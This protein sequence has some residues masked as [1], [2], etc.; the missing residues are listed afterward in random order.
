MQSDDGILYESLEKSLGKEIPLLLRNENINEILLNPDGVIWSDSQIDGLQQVTQIS[1]LQALSIFNKLAGINN[2]IISEKEPI[3][4]VELPYY[5]SMNGERFTGQIPPI[6]SNP[7]FTIRKK[8]EKVFTLND[9]CASNRLTDKQKNI[10]TKLIIDKKNILVCGGPGSGKTTVTNA[11]IIEAIKSDPNQRF[12][13]LEDTPE[14]RCKA[15]NTVYLFTSPEISMQQLLKTSMRMRPDRILIGEVRGKEAL[16]ML[17]AWNTG[18][19]GGICTVHANGVYDAVQRII[20]LAMESEIKE[21]PISLLTHTVDAIVSVTRRGSQ[22]GFINEILKLN[23]VK[24]GEF[25]FEKIG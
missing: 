22:K 21:P 15:K 13:I 10:L 1:T 3:L 18:C 19:Q 2:K 14:L 24:N 4:E 6:V 11:L 23:G 12:V 8:S 25:I 20:D 16:D 17:K 7:T 5:K 9:Y